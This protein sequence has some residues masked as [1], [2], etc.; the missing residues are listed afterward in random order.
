MQLSTKLEM[1]LTFMW[2]IAFFMYFLYKIHVERQ[3]TINKS[4]EIWYT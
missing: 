1:K 4:V 3:K 2:I